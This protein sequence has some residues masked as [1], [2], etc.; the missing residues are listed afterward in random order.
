MWNIDTTDIQK[1]ELRHTITGYNWEVN[2]IAFNP[3]GQSLASG[4]RRKNIKLW[5]VSTGQLGKVFKGHR[6][7]LWVQSIAFSPNGDTL[8]SLSISI[9]SSDH[10]AE[11]LLWDAAT[12]EYIIT[13][14]GHGKAIGRTI[15]L[16][17]SSIAFSPDGKTLVSGSLD[18]TARLWNPKTAASNSFFD[19]LWRTFFG[20]HKAT[21]KGH[22]DHVLAVA[23]NPDGRTIASGSSDKTVR[24]WD[25]H[26]RK[27]KAT[28]I[29]HKTGIKCAAFSPNGRTLA[30]SGNE[31]GTIYLWDIDTTDRIATL[32]M[33]PRIRNTLNS[34]VFSPDGNIL[35]SGGNGLL[36]NGSW[37][38]AIFLWDMNTHQLKTTLIGHKSSVSSVAFSP[39]GRTLA[40]G[41]VDGT[42][43]I[44]ELEP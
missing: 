28:L 2:S 32:V 16:H 14:K 13:L 1:S 37:A 15:P 25:L 43:L 34:L 31:D 7:P 11:I 36:P 3:N 40:S 23:L 10:K 33:N 18:G 4:Y 19:R 17:S 35:A 42:I 39:D 24:L 27:L 29:G 44:W 8:A 26:T 22:T 9:Q 6:Y 21:L 20:Q 41:S 5:D 38:G 30:S 12:G